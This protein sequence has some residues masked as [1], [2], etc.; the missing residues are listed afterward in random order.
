M[1]EVVLTLLKQILIILIVC[2]YVF[3]AIEASLD[4]F[5]YLRHPNM[6]DFIYAYIFVLRFP[7]VIKYNWLMSTCRI[8]ECRATGILNQVN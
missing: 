2:I 1:S 4:Y 5:I 7:T 3:H 6:E 8:L